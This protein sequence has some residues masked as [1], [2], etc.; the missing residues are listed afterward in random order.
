VRAVQHAVARAANACEA[1][2]AEQPVPKN[3]AR[4]EPFVRLAESVPARQIAAVE[5]RRPTVFHQIRGVA[6]GVA[7]IQ[8]GPLLGHQVGLAGQ[9]RRY[10]NSEKPD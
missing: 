9:G 8:L 2:G 7:I 1:R 6:V 10:Q 4:R 5:Q 3:R